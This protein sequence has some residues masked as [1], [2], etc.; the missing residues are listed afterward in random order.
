MLSYLMMTTDPS[1]WGYVVHAGAVVKLVMLLLTIASIASWTI[2]F[3]RG[4]I[5]KNAR[6][7]MN[8]DIKKEV[9]NNDFF[10]L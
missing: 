2:I 4:K 5:L 3:Q 8:K 10:A 7:D 6:R 1:F 9:M